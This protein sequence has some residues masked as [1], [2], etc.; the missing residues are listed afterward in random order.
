MEYKITYEVYDDIGQ[1][2]G[3][4]ASLLHEARAATKHA[5]A[6]YSGFRVAAVLL[7]ANGERVTGTN[8]ENASFPVGIC[9]ERTALSAASSLYPDVAVLTIAVSYDAESGSHQPV[10]PCGIC[11]QTLVEYQQRFNTPIRLVLGG[12]TGPVYI[13]PDAAEL[14][15]L[16]FSAG[17]MK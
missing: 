10:S 6:P 1:L 14:L 11:R 3:T 13:I 16:S 5:Y 15:P 17:N 9:A 12:Q 7:M 4:D 8:Q 2:S